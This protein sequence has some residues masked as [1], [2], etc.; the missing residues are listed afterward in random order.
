[1]L[2]RGT[3]NSCAAAP[4]L[5]A[6]QWLLVALQ[7][8]S[9]SATEHTRESTRRVL[10]ALLPSTAVQNSVAAWVSPRQPRLAVGTLGKR[11]FTKPLLHCVQPLPL[12]PRHVASKVRRRVYEPA[13]TVYHG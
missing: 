6:R 13:L 7:E 3:H 9:I 11:P 10:A 8:D 12:P 5:A 1:M 2:E 4:S